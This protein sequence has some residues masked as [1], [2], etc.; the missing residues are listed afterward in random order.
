MY[1]LFSKYFKHIVTFMKLLLKLKILHNGPYHYIYQDIKKYT[2]L[3]QITRWIYDFFGLPDVIFVAI[4]KMSRKKIIFKCVNLLHVRIRTFCVLNK[5]VVT[6][7]KILLLIYS[8]I[9]YWTVQQT[10][11]TMTFVTIVF[12]FYQ[13]L[14]FFFQS[15]V[16]SSLLSLPFATS[17]AFDCNSFSVHVPFISVFEP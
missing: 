5:N 8:F 4:S 1:T 16:K 17:L 10:C 11:W 3:F 7:F 14:F 13:S 9:I 6:F 2:G 12:H 15:N